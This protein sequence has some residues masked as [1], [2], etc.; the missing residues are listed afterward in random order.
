M[1]RKK[2]RDIDHKTY[3]DLV[4]RDYWIKCGRVIQGLLSVYAAQCWS[5][6]V[7]TSTDLAVKY[8]F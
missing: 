6:T 5:V 7:D 2:K 8:E 1:T 3:Q 4:F